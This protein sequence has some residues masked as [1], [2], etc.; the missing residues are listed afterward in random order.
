MLS[1]RGSQVRTLTNPNPQPQPQPRSEML[2][3]RDSQRIELCNLTALQL[4]VKL[5]NKR[6]FQHA[7]RKSCDVV[8]Q[9]GPVTSYILDLTPID[10]LNPGGNN[11]MELIGRLDA[12]E[13]TIEMVCR[14][15]RPPWSV[16]VRRRRASVRGRADTA[17]GRLHA[18]LPS[19]AVR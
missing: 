18:G 14:G 2:S 3:C 4:A 7:L 9:W 10:S 16:I 17:D 11:V 19:H 15:W 5:G 8:W 12:L 6:L 1:Y 13:S